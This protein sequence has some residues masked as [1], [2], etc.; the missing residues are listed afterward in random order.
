MEIII[1]K[2]IMKYDFNKRGTGNLI[3]LAMLLDGLDHFR[4]ICLF[5]VS[6]SS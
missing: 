2:I 5:A 6:D 1:N 4:S 3:I